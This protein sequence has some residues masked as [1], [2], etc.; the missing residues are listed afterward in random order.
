MMCWQSLL[1]PSPLAYRLFIHCS[2]DR[3][4]AFSS[5][6]QL[7]AEDY[8]SM[9]SFESGYTF[10]LIILMWYKKRRKV[11]RK[12]LKYSN[13]QNPSHQFPRNFSVNGEAVNLSSYFNNI[14]KYSA[15]ES[16]TWINKKYDV[17][18]IANLLRICYYGETGVY[19]SCMLSL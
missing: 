6:S 10:G 2:A 18:S 4:L 15:E 14:S 17:L 5:H 12:T 11:Q 8:A 7:A 19:G 1:P 13:A 16:N 3:D 9:I